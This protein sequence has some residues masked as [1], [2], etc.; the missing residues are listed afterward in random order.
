MGTSSF[1]ESFFLQ[2]RQKDLPKILSLLGN[3]SQRTLKKL[4]K[5]APKKKKR[6]K[7]KIFIFT[8][9]QGANEV[10]L[11]AKSILKLPQKKLLFS[12]LNLLKSDLMI[13]FLPRVKLK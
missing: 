2:A 11:D 3:L 4:P 5:H 12:L 8:F 10:L 6:K 9:F 1:K 7:R 13:A